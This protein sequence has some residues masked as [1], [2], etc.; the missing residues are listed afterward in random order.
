M[1]WRTPFG[2]SLCLI[3]AGLFFARPLYKRKLVTLVDFYRQ[4]YGRGV[5]LYTSLAIIVSY[6]GWVG[7]QLKALGLVFFV[8]SGG[9]V[10]R[11][12]GM[13]AGAL[14][15]LAYT[16]AGGMLSVAITDLVQMVVVMAGM[17]FMVFF[18]ASEIPG[19]A[20]AVVSHAWQASKLDLMPD[21][22]LAGILAFVTLTPQ[23][24]PVLQVGDE[25]RFC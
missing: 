5:E 19:G 22:S 4:R 8:V 23:E 15:V 17:V 3:L 9:T 14:T 10:S 25:L 11:D 21:M 20:A 24:G 1:S 18:F 2:A 7:A 6:L 12:A 16:L 13:I